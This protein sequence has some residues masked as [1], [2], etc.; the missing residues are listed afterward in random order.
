MSSGFG[1]WVVN[2]LGTV[3]AAAALLVTV[4][5]WLI[6]HQ[7][8]S[9]RLTYRV[10]MDAP[11]RADKK[12]STTTS[13][14]I[15]D[16]VDFVV[17]HKGTQ[18]EILVPS[19]VLVRIANKGRAAVA[20][21]E[22]NLVGPSFTFGDREVEAFKALEVEEKALGLALAPLEGA[23]AR[24]AEQEERDTKKPRKTGVIIRGNELSLPALTLN[25]SDRFKLLILLT[26][27][28]SYIKG[29]GQFTGGKLKKEEGTDRP[30][31]RTMAYL[32]ISVALAGALS[33][34]IAAGLGTKSSQVSAFQCAS[35]AISI[36]GSTA[37]QP[38][39][40]KIASGYER[41]CSGAVITVM[42]TGSIAGIN[43]LNDGS[44]SAALYDGT[45][46]RGAYPSL[47]PH[48]IGVVEF[49]M[50]VNRQTGVHNLTTTQL[51]AIYSLRYTNWRQAGGNDLPITIVARDSES[52]T[53]YTF[54]N[55]VLG[56]Q[57]E[58]TPNSQD[59]IT[60]EAGQN[61][62]VHVCEMNSTKALL[63]NVND[64]PGAIG[65]AD[66]YQ[67]GS[68][69]YADISYIQI[70]G[71]APDIQQNQQSAYPFW[72]LEHVYTRGTPPNGSLLAAFLSYL[73]S[74]TAKNTMEAN[75]DVPCANLPP[76]RELA[77]CGS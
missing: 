44:V 65:Y 14:E 59:C 77:D 19:L 33:G 2:N 56:G 61:S 26:G 52:G 64:I 5:T 46:T 75:G 3:I 54:K 72:A 24:K 71:L 25:P 58:P 37:F 35:G 10:H 27:K 30:G 51:Q 60:P 47:V 38:A 55:T 4:T 66:A 49:A 70:N 32:A 69:V 74:D 17:R 21:E 28:G 40:S 20:A 1:H 8:Q 15:D 73:T 36:A 41:K 43:A 39:V 67:A 34:F 18:K 23:E 53:R 45:P 50:V 11:I 13:S 68:A 16:L 57:P 22:F 31:R 42:G 12:L 63:Q 29:D 6:D 62:P 48:A 7:R 76:P 9:K